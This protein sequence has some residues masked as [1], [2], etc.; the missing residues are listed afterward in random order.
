MKGWKTGKLILWILFIFSIG[1][2]L[3][4]VAKKYSLVIS[5]INVAEATLVL[6]FATFA[7]IM[8][9]P[10]LSTVNKPVIA[11]L[12]KKRMEYPSDYLSDISI[13]ILR[14]IEKEGGI[15]INIRI[16]LRNDG[17]S[18]A[19]DVY[20]KLLSITRINIGTGSR[21]SYV[22]FTPYKLQW[23]SLNNTIN[24]VTVSS[25]PGITIQGNLSPGESEYLNLCTLSLNYDINPDTLL[26][27]VGFFLN[28]EN[29][30]QYNPLNESTIGHVE[31]SNYEVLSTN[32]KWDKGKIIG[33]GK[34]TFE[35]DVI[36]GG[37][38]VMPQRYLFT[39]SY[40]LEEDK[41]DLAQIVEQYEYEQPLDR[42]KDVLH[43]LFEKEFK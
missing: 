41:V 24:G 13:F 19:R 2:I 31:K 6:A 21:I 10:I 28:P 34:T 9:D 29:P 8:K 39:I 37:S 33:L 1:V 25:A 35:F 32:L 5:K 14:K 17:K 3:F 30:L 36:V 40:Y 11:V 43:I 15:K 23:V 18:T 7:A 27:E 42:L 20:A 16:M 22:P 26:E 4:L 12:P 38:N